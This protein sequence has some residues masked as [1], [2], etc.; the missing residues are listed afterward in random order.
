MLGVP[1]H[2]FQKFAL[3]EAGKL[4]QAS[5]F[6]KHHLFQKIYSNIVGGSTAPTV[7]L[8]VG[9]VETLCLRVALIEMEVKI[10]AAIS[11]DQKAGEHVVLAFV[12]AALADFSPL[13]LHLLKY[14][15]FDDRLVDVLEDDPILTVILQPLFVLVGFGV[16]LEVE[17]VTAILLQ[18][19]DF[20]YDVTVSLGSGLL[21]ALSGPLDALL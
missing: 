15:P 19:Q 4:R 21:L 11:T 10:A 14:G 3:I 17:N 6:T 7:A 5:D 9:A 8:I 18:R 20:G 13:L 1:D 12:G 2:R 16:G